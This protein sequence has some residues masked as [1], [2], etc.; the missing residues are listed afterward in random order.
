MIKPNLPNRD[1]KKII[2]SCDITERMQDALLNH[3]VKIFKLHGEMNCDRA[4]RNHSDLY[5][6]HCSED[7]VLFAENICSIEREADLNFKYR[8]IETQFSTIDVIKYPEDVFFN[9]LILGNRLICCRR[10]VHP[11]AIEFARE[12]NYDIINVNQGYTK[13]NICVVNENAIITEDNGIAKV[14]LDFGF[15]V[16]LLEKN[17]VK[18][19]GYKYGFI[20]GASGKIA[21]DKLA[22][23]GDIAK[24]PEY[25]RILS[26][27]VRHDVAPVSLSDE[28][29]EDFGSLIPIE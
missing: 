16:L 3:G 20:G 7:L 8:G 10:F 11:S 13:C 9:S 5:L 1:V 27:L 14:L 12:H 28:P 26:F 4:V 17:S 29:L 2:A 6:L 24:H 15:D 25:D 21:D 23:C 19:P 22:F 18:L